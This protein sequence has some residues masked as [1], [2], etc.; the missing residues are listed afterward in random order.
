MNLKHKSEKWRGFNL[1]KNNDLG[2]FDY[3][4]E[5]MSDPEKNKIALAYALEIRK[6]EIDLYWKRASY[7]WTFIGASLVG[8]ISIQSLTSTQASSKEILTILICCLG[9]VFSFSWYCVNRGS[10]FWQENWEK[11]VDSLE[12]S[13]SGPL[14]KIV[15]SPQKIKGLSGR[16]RH[17][18]TGSKPMSVSKINQII[19]LYVTILWVILLVSSLPEFSSEYSINWPVTFLVSS[20]IIVCLLVFFYCETAIDFSESIWTKRN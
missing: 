8:F 15:A 4:R 9:L 7:F 1:L 14:Y 17:F 13:I 10:K 16:T 11:H 2:D 6:F 20:S 19:S 5:F 3:R 18:L 12:D